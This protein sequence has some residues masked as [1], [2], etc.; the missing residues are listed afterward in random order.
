M[1]GG[2]D[3]H[4]GCIVL[5]NLYLTFVLWQDRNGDGMIQRNECFGIV[6][7]CVFSS[8]ENFLT[9]YKDE[10]NRRH[11]VCINKN[12]GNQTEHGVPP[13]GYIIYDYNVDLGI[14][15]VYKQYPDGTRVLIYEGVPSGYDWEGI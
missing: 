13:G 6:G 14:L 12:T 7:Q 9:A 5:D 4:F 1:P 10:N 8:G 11:V 2:G 3:I 15:K